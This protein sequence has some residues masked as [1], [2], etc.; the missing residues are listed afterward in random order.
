MPYLAP[1]E[2]KLVFGENA[3][4]SGTHAFATVQGDVVDTY[5]DGKRIRFPGVE[6]SYLD[7]RV[8]RVFNIWT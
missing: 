3:N 5:T 4:A 1:N 7:F 6:G 8:K 2:L